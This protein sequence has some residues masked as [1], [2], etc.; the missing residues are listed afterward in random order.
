MNKEMLINSF[1]DW[2]ANNSETDVPCFHDFAESEINRLLKSE[3]PGETL[4]ENDSVFIGSYEYEFC[5]SDTRKTGGEV[6][7]FLFEAIGIGSKENVCEGDYELAD[8]S[9]HTYIIKK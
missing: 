1:A 3:A 5:L 6:I 4:F 8:Y 7:S 2:L 9:E